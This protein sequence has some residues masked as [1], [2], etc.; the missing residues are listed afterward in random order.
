[1]DALELS[2]CAAGYGS[3]YS[4]EDLPSND[5]GGNAPLTDEVIEMQYSP[6]EKGVMPKKKKNI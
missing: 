1:M 6:I 5:F 2:Q 3:C 4:Y